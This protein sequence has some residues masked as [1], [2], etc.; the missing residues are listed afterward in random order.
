MKLHEIFTEPLVDNIINKVVKSPQSDFYNKMMTD[1]KP[2]GEVEGGDEPPTVIKEIV[3]KL[4][5]DLHEDSI[6]MELGGSFYQRRCG[7][8]KDHF[9][10][11]FPVSLSEMNMIR[12]SSEFQR[13]SVA[14][15]A[16]D[17]P[18][19]DS[20]VD[21]VFTNTFLEHPENLEA[22]IREIIHC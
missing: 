9:K 18:I 19:I 13:I 16:A 12:Y 20:S 8:L 6:L 1:M 17:L 2:K 10:N 22:V 21:A 15:D 3:K 7:Y 4:C 11:Y 14:A 5:E